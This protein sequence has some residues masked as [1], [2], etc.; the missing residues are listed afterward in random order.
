MGYGQP[1][2]DSVDYYT[3]NYEATLTNG[4]NDVNVEKY[5]FLEKDLTEIGFKNF[6]HNIGKTGPGDGHGNWIWVRVQK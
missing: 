6:E 3:N 2:H 4:G 1:K 5:E